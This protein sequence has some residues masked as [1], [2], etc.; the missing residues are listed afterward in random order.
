MKESSLTWSI[1]ILYIGSYSKRI[2]NSSEAKASGLKSVDTGLGTMLTNSPSKTRRSQGQ[3]RG[4]C[5]YIHTSESYNALYRK[6]LSNR[7]NHMISS[8]FKSKVIFIYDLY[9]NHSL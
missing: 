1:A 3:T 4:G 2:P 5:K 7:A 8:T 6:N 9:S